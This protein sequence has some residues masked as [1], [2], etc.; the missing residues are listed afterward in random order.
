LSGEE[1]RFHAPIGFAGKNMTMRRAMRHVVGLVLTLALASGDAAVARAHAVLLEAD[2]PDG[3]VVAHSPA[4]IALRFNETVTPVFVRVLDAAGHAVATLSRATAV[5]ETVHLKLPAALP[6]GT[7]VVSYRVISADSH[8]VGES[9]LFAIGPPDTVIGAARTLREGDGVWLTL[10]LLDRT[11]LDAGFLIA[12]GGALFALVLQRRRP[13][14]RSARLTVYVAALTAA[15]A[16]LVAIG[17]EGGLAIETPLGGLAAGAV[18]SAGLATTVGRS[19]A[20]LVVGLVVLAAGLGRADSRQLV[21]VLLGAGLAAAGY[22]VTGHVAIAE[23]RWLAAPSLWLHVVCVAFWVGSLPPMFWMLRGDPARV[24][25]VVARFGR[26]ATPVVV[27]L[28]IAGA[29]MAW[30]QLARPLDFV[31]TPYGERLAFKLG[32]VTALLLVASTNRIVLTPRLLRGQP[33]TVRWFRRSIAV[34]LALMAA[35]VATTATLG[36]ATP[37][38]A[39]AEQAQA[40]RHMAAPASRPGYFVMIADRGLSAFLEIEPARPGRNRIRLDLADTGDAPISPLEL[41]LSLANAAL[42]IEPSEHAATRSG[43]GSYE[44]ADLPIPVSGTWT[45]SIAALVDDFDR[46]TVATEVPI[47]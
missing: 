24:A 29:A 32:L 12:V 47:R 41:R 45:F 5:D 36:Q 40:M 44:I 26:V 16:A 25:P 27:A 15:V 19:A 3:A 8:P 7:Y 20:L 21:L 2:P 46:R 17:I 23:P 1:E 43:P 28:A 11:A 13:I 37:P 42:G 34:E 30:L 31:T 4:D 6:A 22:A 9:L 38:R 10:A 35:I 18:W 14:P 39:L 33:R